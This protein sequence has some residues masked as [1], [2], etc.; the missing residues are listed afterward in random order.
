MT[1]AREDN[2]LG[3]EE[4]RESCVIEKA[5]AGNPAVNEKIEA[6]QAVRLGQRA[7]AIMSAAVNNYAS[8]ADAY[9]ALVELESKMMVEGCAR[10]MLN[11]QKRRAQDIGNDMARKE[12][13]YDNHAHD[14]TSRYLAIKR[15][16]TVLD[17]GMEYMY[18]A[19]GIDPSTIDIKL[20]Q[21]DPDIKNLNATRT[22]PFWQQSDTA[23]PQGRLD[24]GT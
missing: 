5:G 22:K 20:I 7:E 16:A 14:R 23:E 18:I 9:D 17:R 2:V 11:G 8:P 6:E 19:A 12:G 4:P 10:M 13:K 1:T 24:L 21:D 3:G 15:D